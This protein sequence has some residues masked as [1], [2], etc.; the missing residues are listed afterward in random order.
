MTTT[1]TGLGL[2]PPLPEPDSIGA[3]EASGASGLESV[4]RPR[5]GLTPT[6][7][8]IQV[9]VDA[10]SRVAMLECH[11]RPCGTG[12]LVGVD[13]L[14]T[15]FHVLGLEIAQPSVEGL[16]A[17]FDFVG[18]DGVSPAESGVRVQVAEF[19]TGSPPRTAEIAPYASGADAD[20][21][22]EAGLLDFALLRLAA[23]AFGFRP[24]HAGSAP[25]G[26]YELSSTP[27]AFDTRS[28]LYIVQHPL[29][30]VQ[31][32]AEG[33]SAQIISG[34]SRVR[35]QTNTLQGS[36]GSPVIDSRGRLVAIHHYSEGGFNQGVPTSAIAVALLAGQFGYVLSAPDQPPQAAA[37]PAIARPP[38][39]P[40]TMAD[41][42]HFLM[43]CEYEQA[44]DVLY[45]A[46]SDGNP[47]AVEIL[48]AQL[49]DLGRYADAEDVE[50]CLKTDTASLVTLID[51]IHGE[52]GDR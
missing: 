26:F 20:D 29:G 27:Y 22:A 42:R 8:L 1:P 7:A 10:K 34:G 30:D 9:L 39:P 46:S 31:K 43:M 28:V 50:R 21:E 32:V 33:S 44:Q 48:A 37:A 15:A 40:P 47:E 45:A 16:T 19:L 25:R 51:R 18:A 11:G 41:Y 38:G 24:L 13:L 6:G 52:D 35:Y 2:D 23:P 5:T 17:V 4:N 12:F 49:R 3:E 36:S 14:L